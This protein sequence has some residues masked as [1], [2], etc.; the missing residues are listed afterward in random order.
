MPGLDDL[1]YMLGEMNGKLDLLVKQ[2]AAQDDRATALEARFQS[3]HDALETRVRV[4]ESRQHW[5]AGAAAVLGAASSY[6]IKGLIGH[7]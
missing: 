5:Y 3:R 2:G 4:V 1:H 6:I 7:G